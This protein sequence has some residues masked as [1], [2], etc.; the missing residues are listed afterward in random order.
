MYFNM[1]SG[2]MVSNT[3][4]IEMYPIYIIVE[5]YQPKRYR[6]FGIF[7]DIHYFRRVFI[8]ILS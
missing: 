5:N 4:I 1:I 6:G 2:I 3:V 7:Q 8:V